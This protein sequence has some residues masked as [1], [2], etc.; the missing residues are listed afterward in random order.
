MTSFTVDVI[1]ASFGERHN[2]PKAYRLE[3][4]QAYWPNKP[5][6]LH[7]MSKH[8]LSWIKE[9]AP[10]VDTVFFHLDIDEEVSAVISL[11][12]ELGLKV[13]ICAAMTD[14]LSRL[15]DYAL[16][17]D[18]VMLLSIKVPGTSGQKFDIAALDRI[19]E[20]NSWDE[21]GH[22]ELCVDGGVNEK[23]VNLLNVESVVSGSSVLNSDDP[24]RQIMRLQT[25]S[26][27][28]KL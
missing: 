8:P 9:S 23:I 15:H 18:T 1:D 4:I 10:F 28:E 27:Y 6:H 7:I 3:V 2:D 25:S 12:R 16:D 5:V 26:N 11:L 22:L 19:V 20:V 13:G 17:L 24:V 21:R 14:D